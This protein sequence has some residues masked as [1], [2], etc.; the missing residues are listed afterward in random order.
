MRL[1]QNVDTVYALASLEIQVQSLRTRMIGIRV[2]QPRPSARWCDG[3]L[4]SRLGRYRFFA[5]SELLLTVT[6]EEEECEV[7]I[8]GVR[9]SQRVNCGKG[10]ETVCPGNGSVGD[11]SEN[12]ISIQTHT[13]NGNEN[14]QR[15][16]V[17]SVAQWTVAHLN[18]FNLH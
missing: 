5:R 15:A 6:I 11:C 9:L 12:V 10:F 3:V 14:E 13:Q 17:A 7:E 8:E 1:R 18:A 2:M 4:D 16:G